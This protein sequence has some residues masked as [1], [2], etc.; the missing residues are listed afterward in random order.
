MG[1]TITWPGFSG[2]EVLQITGMDQVVASRGLDP[3]SAMNLGAWP[4]ARQV[5]EPRREMCRVETC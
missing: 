3:T 4:S 2:P 1:H 5:S